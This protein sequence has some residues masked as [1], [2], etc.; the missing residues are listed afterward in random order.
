MEPREALIDRAVR[1]LEAG[2]ASGALLVDQKFINWVEFSLQHSDLGMLRESAQQ[3]NVVL[4][5][6]CERLAKVE[7]IMAPHRLNAGRGVR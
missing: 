2:V 3:N 1:Y 7:L 5:E 6:V 4:K